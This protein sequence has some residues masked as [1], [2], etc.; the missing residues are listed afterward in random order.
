MRRPT[1]GIAT[2]AAHSMKNGKTEYQAINLAT[3]ERIFYRNLGN[4]TTNIGEFLAVVE[5]VKYIIENDFQPR[6]IFTD[7]MT[8]IA[9]FKAK[10]TSSTKPNKDLQRAEM[11]LR[12][13]SADVDT[14]EVIHWDNKRW[15]ETPADFGRK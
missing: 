12:A 1:E 11:F 6:V 13:L 2:D 9:W 8:A 3:R 10:K 14:I 5:A 4:Q 7:S 15:G